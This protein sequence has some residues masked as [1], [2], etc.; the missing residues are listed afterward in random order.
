LSHYNHETPVRSVLVTSA[1]GGEG[2]STVAWNLA[3]TGA[4]AGA[5][6][7][8]I[9]AD[10]RRPTIASRIGAD[11]DIGL[12]DVLSRRGLPLN[13]VIKAVPLS[14]RPGALLAPGGFDDGAINGNGHALESGNSPGEGSLGNG[15]LGNGSSGNGSSDN[16]SRGNGTEAVPVGAN[17]SD[18]EDAG[19]HR[20]AYERYRR[21]WRGVDPRVAQKSH[22]VSQPVASPPSQPSRAPE[23]LPVERANL[24]VLFA[25]HRAERRGFLQRSPGAMLASAQMRDLIHAAEGVYDLVVI[26]S[27]PTTAVSDAVPLVKH[28]SGVLVVSRV[29]KNTRDSAAH[30]RVQ[31]ENLK[32]R[33]IGV[34]V[35][36]IDSTDGYYSSAT[37]YLDNEP[38]R[39]NTRSGG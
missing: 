2:K 18:V 13:Q 4:R 35:N 17:G 25:G 21:R 34:V 24:E 14:A 27:P 10:L 15:S 5:K 37:D 20:S 31:L 16:G 19:S 11:V 1:K 28:V 29:T 22:R 6:V 3:L 9:E 26:D 12:V 30:L 38:K 39:K 33:T 8:L 23:V 36:G 7:L 32:A